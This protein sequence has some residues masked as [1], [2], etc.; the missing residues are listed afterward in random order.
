MQ[1]GRPPSCDLVRAASEGDPTKRHAAFECLVRQFQ[2]LAYGCAYGI[3]GHFHLAQDASQDA[4]LTAY[5]ELGKL[6]APE[7]FPGW[8]KRIVI[9]KALRLSQTRRLP[10][11][12]IEV[13]LSVSTDGPD[14]MEQI[15]TQETQ[16]LV[17]AAIEALPEHERIVTVLFYLTEYSQK[18]I[19][20]F[21]DLS[22]PS[23][24][25]RLLEVPEAA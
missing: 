25:K 17:H 6:E 12:P 8:F 5:T 21:L 15:E 19:A 22:L 4:F 11:E 24:K 18:K 7:A 23:V 2:D 20:E 14:Q 13:A 16:S 9:R 1:S 10:F 3:L